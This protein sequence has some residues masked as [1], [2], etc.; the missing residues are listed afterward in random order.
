[1]YYDH[2]HKQVNIKECFSLSGMYLTLMGA[3]EDFHE[4]LLIMFG[5]NIHWLNILDI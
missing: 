1:M 2:K 5:C 3:C 4:E